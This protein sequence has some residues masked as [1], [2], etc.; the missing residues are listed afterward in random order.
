MPCFVVANRT[1][2]GLEGIN[3]R[4][5]TWDELRSDEE[6][7]EVL[8]APLDESLFVAGPPGCGKTSL[9]VWRADA[10]VDWYEERI[11]AITYNRMLRRTLQLAADENQIGIDAST[12]QSFVWQ[13]F[14]RHT[15][16]QPPTVPPDPYEYHWEAM[17][18][19]LAGTESDR[20]VL[21]VDEGQDLPE[22]FFVYASRYVARTMTVFADDDQAIS[23]RRSTL[24]QIRSAAGLPNPLILSE[25]HR[26]TPEIAQLAEH[27]HTGRLPVATVIRSP[28][29][30]VPRLVR[31]RSVPSTIKQIANE[32]QNRGGSVGVIVDQ[33]STVKSVYKS[34]RDHLQGRH[35]ARYTNKLKNENSIDVRK[36]GITVL[37][38]ESVKGQE[39][40]TVF[41]LELDRFIPC[42]NDAEFRAMYMMCSRARDN[43]LLVHGPE[44]LS[45][46]AEAALP[47]ADILDR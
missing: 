28:S 37:T 26:N 2:F 21:V 8:E 23:G 29:G 4:L 15:H 14:W 16:N 10:L 19:R 40:D 5:P 46:E 11:P 38:K 34:L 6:Q 35:V 47:A 41:I 3:V 7:L 17:I 20:D 32:F 1:R 39:F 25:N 30:D 45:T 12:M 36:P 33:D 13:D 31:S 43:L 22:G 18:E 24:E 42:T 9:A 44:P 27:F